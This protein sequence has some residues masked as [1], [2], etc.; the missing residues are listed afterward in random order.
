MNELT[1]GQDAEGQPFTLPAEVLTRH[2][3]ILAKRGAGKT[4]TAGVIEEEFAKAG[5]PF[6][7]LDP[8][9]VHWGIRSDKK[10]RRSA[11]PVVVFGGEHADIPIERHMGRA[12]AQAVVEENISCIVD[13][14]ELS[15]AAWRQFVAD[16]CRELYQLN[17]TPRHVF[18]EEATEFVPQTRRPEMQV[19]YEAVERLVRMG[20]N[21][22]IGC[23]LI[24]QRSA[25]VAKDVLTQMDVLIALRT[26]GIQDRKAL[27]DMFE[28]V[29]EEDELV[30]LEAFKRDIVRLPDGTAWIW[31]PEFLKTFTQV[32]I[33]ERETYHAGATPAFGDVKVVQARP[34]VRALKA[35]F[36]ATAEP[37]KPT[38]QKGKAASPAQCTGHLE[39]IRELERDRATATER[40]REIMASA[41]QY[42]QALAEAQE[43]LDPLRER[44]EQLQHQV[45]GVG[46]LRSGLVALLGDSAG[47]GDAVAA[48]DEDALLERLVA[49]LPAGSAPVVQVTPPEALRKKYLQSA[50]DRLMAKIPGAGDG[51]TVMELLLGQEVFWSI[52]RMSKALTGNDSGGTRKRWGDAVRGLATVGL[53]EK[54][55]SGRSEFRANVRSCVE[56]ELAPHGGTPEEV[57]AV[58]QQVLYR[59][60]SEMDRKAT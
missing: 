12:I 49:R 50:A 48:V 57:T 15:K 8:V 46:S 44:V 18:I 34:D 31:S 54:G 56:V 1:I 5:L 27:L 52:N 6:V 59:L 23:T 45:N 16:F 29:L 51:R 26:V 32:R 42:Q 40:E 55:G 30:H 10:G 43:E 35:R 36:A 38:K 9:G 13:L 58:E 28:A 4:Y 53:V 17:R 25:Q 39:R 14:T 37:E 60:T 21:R 2:M 22:G 11:Y 47:A 24:S 3:A 7:V 19:A 41:L 33:R 20:R